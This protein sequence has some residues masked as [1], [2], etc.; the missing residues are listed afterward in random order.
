VHPQV[1]A[2]ALGLVLLLP[3][4]LADIGSFFAGCGRFAETLQH[5]VLA[6]KDFFH[7]P[8][9]EDKPVVERFG[10]RVRFPEFARQTC[11]EWEDDFYNGRWFTLSPAE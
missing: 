5:G 11:K 7:V 9:H 3:V 6:L 4:G 8:L 2:P 1:K 10:F